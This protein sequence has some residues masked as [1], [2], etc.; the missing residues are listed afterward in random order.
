MCNLFQQGVTYTSLSVCFCICILPRRSFCIFPFSTELPIRLFSYIP[1][2]HM[3]VCV[4]SCIYSMR[5][6]PVCVCAFQ[7]IC[8]YLVSILSWGFSWLDSYC[9]ITH[10]NFPHT[11]TLTRHSHS[12]ALRT[13]IE[14][15][16]GKWLKNVNFS[17]CLAAHTHTHGKNSRAKCR[18]RKSRALKRF[19]VF[20]FQTRRWQLATRAP[21]NGNDNGRQQAEATGRQPT[22]DRRRTADDNRQPTDSRRKT[23]GRRAARENTERNGTERAT[24][25]AEAMGKWK[26]GKRSTITK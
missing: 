1:H 22:D 23:D 3:C 16:S 7:T 26:W 14:K 25:A 10:R 4:Y 2:I 20:Q 17:V 13:W 5:F 18:R 9:F 15:N 24:V 19:Y 8:N 21:A 12:D 6:T 11:Q